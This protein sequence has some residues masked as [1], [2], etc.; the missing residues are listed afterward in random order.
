VVLVN[1]MNWNRK[2]KALLSLG[3]ATATAVGF[4]A[5]TAAGAAATPVSGLTFTAPVIGVGSGS[6]TVTRANQAVTVDVSPSTTYSEQGAGSASFSNVLI[7]ERVKVTGSIT[8]NIKVVDASHVEVLRLLP[9]DFDGTV[10]SLGTGSFMAVRG[11]SPI[12]VMVS[13]KTAFSVGGVAASFASLAD[14]D[15]VIVHGTSNPGGTVVNAAQVYVLSFG[16]LKFTATVTS[17][18]SGTFDVRRINEPVTVEVSAKTAYGESGLRSA[19]FADVKTGERVTVDA[20]DTA[21]PNVLKA[22]HVQITPLAPMDISATVV[23]VGTSMFSVLKGNTRITVQVS[24][25]THFTQH[26]I[27]GA[28]LADVMPGDHV[29]VHGTSNPGGTFINAVDVYIVTTS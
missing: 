29:I 13:P 8:S 14:G 3:A 18:G 12:T 21:S 17:V 27:T 15:R 2:G 4:V 10:S 11:T 9:N 23:E 16:S 1:V 22:T 20:T 28:S 7:G 5:I 6:F 24:P 26:G 25:K 19:S